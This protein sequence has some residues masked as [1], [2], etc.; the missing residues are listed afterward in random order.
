M[1]NCLCTD[2]P[3]I[4]DAIEIFLKK[5]NTYKIP[6]NFSLIGLILTNGCSCFT[7]V[8][9]NNA[10]LF[11]FI[12]NMEFVCFENAGMPKRKFCQKMENR[13]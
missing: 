11:R 3:Q 6:L 1:Q 12:L 10:L 9:L 5:L 8:I 2:I 4:S 7:E 13:Q